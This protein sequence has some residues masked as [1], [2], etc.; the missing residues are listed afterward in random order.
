MNSSLVVSSMKIQSYFNWKF[1]NCGSC[2]FN[3]PMKS[4]FGLVISKLIVVVVVVVCLKFS[5]ILWELF[6][7]FY[8]SFIVA[9]GGA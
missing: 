8:C 1:L 4:T 9:I 6:W 3:S 5:T 2:R 7:T